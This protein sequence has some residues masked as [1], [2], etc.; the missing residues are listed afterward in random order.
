M[1]KNRKKRAHWW[2]ENGI[3]IFRIISRETANGIFGVFS[4]VLA[5]FLVLGAFELAGQ[6]GRLTYTSLSYLFGIGYYL[7][8]IVFLLLA[9]SFLREQ[10]RDFAMPQIFGSFFPQE[11]FLHSIPYHLIL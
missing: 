10:E 8:P 1:A 2:G 5:I 4:I 9:V 6:A 3:S 11:G 7:L